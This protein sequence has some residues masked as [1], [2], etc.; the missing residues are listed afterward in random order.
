[1]AEKHSARIA[2]IAKKYGLP[3]LRVYALTSAGTAKSMGRDYAGAERDFAEALQFVRKVNASMEFEPEIL[4][5]LADSYLRMG[6]AERAS[7]VAA[8]AIGI[9][10]QRNT[11]LAECRASIT[12]AV[13]LMAEHGSARLPEAED[14]FRR[15]ETLIHETGARIYEPLLKR[16][17]ARKLTG[18]R[19][20]SS[21][22]REA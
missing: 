21:Y 17:R 15:A 10:R 6:E 14:L 4:A 19:L 16:E 18:D 1:L 7:T 5:S 22:E 8:E 9:A 13:A 20:L 11:R 12:R 3:Y 2:E